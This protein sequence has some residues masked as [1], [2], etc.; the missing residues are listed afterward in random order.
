VQLASAEPDVPPATQIDRCEVDPV[1]RPSGGAFSS[2]RV[3]CDDV[4]EFLAK[5]KVVS[6]SQWRHVYSHVAFGDRTG[7][8]TLR[9]RTVLRSLV[10]PGGLAYLEWPDGHKTYLVRCCVEGPSG[11]APGGTRP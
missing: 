6:A 9:D 7:R 11:I 2:L 4:L 1:A 5:G 3:S 8:L 10:R